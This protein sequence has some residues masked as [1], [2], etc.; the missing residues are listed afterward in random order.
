MKP[1]QFRRLQLHVRFEL[2][3][4]DAA[5]D[6][7][8]SYEF[9]SEVA[10][11]LI[12][13]QKIESEKALASLSVIE[14]DYQD[15]PDG[16]AARLLSEYRK[17][18]SRRRFLEVLE[19]ARSD[20]VPWS[21]VPSIEQVAQQLLPGH[22]VLVTTTPDMNYMVGWGGALVTIY[23]P[24]LHRAN[25]F[26]HVLIGHELF[27]PIVAEFFKTELIKVK[28]KL[29]EDCQAY[30]STLGYQADLFFQQRLDALLNHALNQWEKGLTELMC[31]MGA[32]A[33]FGPSALWSISGF[34]AT[35]NLNSPPTV[36]NQFYP[37]WRLRLKSI[38]DFIVNMDD[39]MTKI[40]RLL[41]TL[42]SA[43]LAQH[44]E[45]VSRCFA[46]ESELFTTADLA[47]DPMR[48][49]TVKVYGHVEASMDAARQFVV[50]AAT[51]FSARW[52]NTL[53]E[54]PK[55]LGRL[56]LNVPPSELLESGKQ[57]S[58]AASLTAITTACW[59]E[60]LVL[61]ENFTLD[62]IQ[63]RRLCRLMLKAIEDSELKRAFS[64]W[65]EG[66]S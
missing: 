46:I 10:S 1:H 59:I 21:L 23:L 52:S 27:H 8:G 41:H 58:K 15:D 12:D 25:G 39:G 24:K 16:S 48:G 54:V 45:L 18:M 62:L 53:D 47:A 33:I 29:R 50:N 38:Y 30:L 57:E 2:D 14:V 56:A 37:P 44:A 40:D 63:F 66:D 6:R 31:D 60:R 36:E 49:L 4:F 17:L 7:L 55:L 32:A 9:P 64:E 51:N 20:E 28:P 26:L 3:R 13:D 42:R 11:V 22:S 5:L 34:A 65:S 61:E 43:G 19:K 35:Q